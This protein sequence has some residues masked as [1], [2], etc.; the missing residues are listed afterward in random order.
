MSDFE[1]C[2]RLYNKNTQNWIF[3]AG[4]LLAFLI[5]RI[6]IQLLNE[7][8]GLQI[9]FTV[10]VFLFTVLYVVSIRF[11]ICRDIVRTLIAGISLGSFIM[12]GFGIVLWIWGKWELVDSTF[13]IIIALYFT[14]LFEIKKMIDHWG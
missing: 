3:F 11:N 10:Y 8:L 9:L 7:S 4:M 2:P 1:T 14:S 13:K 5:E 6:P 12:A